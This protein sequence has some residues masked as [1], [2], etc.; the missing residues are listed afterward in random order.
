MIPTDPVER[1]KRAERLLSDPL[2]KEAFA[3]CDQ[4]VI[5]L[6]RAARDEKA[7][8]AAKDL[9]HARLIFKGIFETAIRDGRLAEDERNPVK[10]GAD[11]LGDI[12]NRK[13]KH[14]AS[15]IV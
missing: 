11:Y 15:K 1:G 12:W 5:E 8:L 2:V 13:R 14:R 7:V 3:L 6:F 9:D 4:H 10:R